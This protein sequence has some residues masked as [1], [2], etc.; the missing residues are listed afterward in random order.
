MR[1]GLAE[2]LGLNEEQLFKLAAENTRRIFPPCVKSMN[3][4]I[5]EMFVKDGMPREVAEMM[6]G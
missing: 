4:V 5:M 1:N 2:Q 6:M 3:D